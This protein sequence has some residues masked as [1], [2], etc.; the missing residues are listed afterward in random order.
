[1][2]GDR[3]GS[4]VVGAAQGAATAAAVHDAAVLLQ[5]HRPHEHQFCGAADERG[6]G[7]QP[8]RVRVRGRHLLRRLLPVRSAEQPRADARRRAALAG[9]DHADV[10]GDRRRDRMGQRP[11]VVLHHAVPARRGRGRAPA[12]TLLL[13]RHLDPGEPSRARPVGAHVDGGAEQRDRRTARDGHHGARRMARV[14]GL[15]ARVHRRGRADRARG[16]RGARLAARDAARGALARAP[17]SATGSKRRLRARTRP[18]RA[19][20]RGRCAR[21]SRTDAC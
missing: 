11:H 10:G 2:R 3:R 6:P 19:S 18:R 5:P 17:P 20:A 1:M 9:A 8:D 13:P 7:L 4:G 15:A 16:R 14:P 21:G 12:G